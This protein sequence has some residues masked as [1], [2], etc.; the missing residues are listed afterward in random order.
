MHFQQQL[1][2]VNL[3]KRMMV[4]CNTSIS[5]SILT[6]SKI[7]LPMQRTTAGR[8]AA[9]AL[10]RG[11]LAAVCPPWILRRAAKLV[12]LIPDMDYLSPAP[13]AEGYG[14]SLTASP[15]QQLASSIWSQR[16]Y[17]VSCKWSPWV[18][19]IYVVA[20]WQNVKNQKWSKKNNLSK[21]YF[22]KKAT[23]R[24]SKWM[25]RMLKQYHFHQHFSLNEGQ[26]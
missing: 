21:W 23:V 12:L 11:W 7:L 9:S 8:T 25:K 15:P 1:K 4:H 14:Q 19:V 10:P 6:S 17:I 2:K 5:K 22:H 18:P 3:P 26:S 24:S 16:P 20:K 13:L